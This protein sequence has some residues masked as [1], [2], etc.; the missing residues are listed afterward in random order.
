MF[1]SVQES[2]GK[3]GTVAV[4]TSGARLPPLGWHQRFDV[5]GWQGARWYARCVYPQFAAGVLNFYENAGFE[6]LLGIALCHSICYWPAAAGG[7]DSEEEAEEQ[8]RISFLGDVKKGGRASKGVLA[9]VADEV[10]P[11]FSL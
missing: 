5:Q 9:G 4:C 10:C 3:E 7:S 8:M 11:Y 2:Q 1:C 6:T